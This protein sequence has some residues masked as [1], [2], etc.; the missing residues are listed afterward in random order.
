MAP[1]DICLL[2]NW[3]IYKRGCGSIGKAKKNDLCGLDLSAI[4][5]LSVHSL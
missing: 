4:L 1:P 2:G 3:R 5:N